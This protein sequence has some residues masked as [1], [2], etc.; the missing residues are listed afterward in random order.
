MHQSAA[1]SELPSRGQLRFLT[2]ASLKTADTLAK[3]TIRDGDAHHHLCAEARSQRRDGGNAAMIEWHAEG[4]SSLSL[5][6]RSSHNDLHIA[7]R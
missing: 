1:S 5:E 6:Y 2:K 4:P 3:A 7:E